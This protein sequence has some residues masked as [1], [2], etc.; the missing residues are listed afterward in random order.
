MHASFSA[1]RLYALL[2]FACAALGAISCGKRD[3][4]A[5][6]PASESPPAS[7]PPSVAT[8]PDTTADTSSTQAS[9]IPARDFA[10]ISHPPKAYLGKSFAYKP[11]VNMTTGVSLRLAKP[12][13]TA[14]RWEQGRILWTPAHPGRYAV[15]IEASLPDG[16]DHKGAKKARQSFILEVS[17]VLN[18]VLRPLPAKAHKGDSIAF[19]LT[20]SRWPAWASASIT[21]RFDWEGDGNWDTESMPLAAQL[22]KRHAY[23]ATGHYTPKIEA[24]YGNFEVR[25]ANGA[26]DIVG[27]VTAALKISP[28]TVEPGSE[29]RVDASAS[30]AEGRL[31]YSLD[32]DGDGKPEWIDSAS[33]QAMLKAPASGLYHPKLTVRDAMGEEDHAEAV[34]RVNARP[35]VE[36]RVR[37]PKDNMAATVDFKIRARDADDSL[38]AVRFTFTGSDQ[39]WE[40]RSAPDSLSEDHAWNLRLRHAYGKVGTYKPKACASSADGREVCQ[41]LKIEIFNAPPESRPGGDLRATLGQPL[42]IDGTG[43]DP[44][45]KIVKWEWDLDGDGKYELVST[46]NGKFQYTFSKEGTFTLVL[47][48]TTADGMTATGKRKV[49]VRKKWKT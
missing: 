32:V 31:R 7:A 30:H 1:P 23:A 6:A 13:D 38:R 37:N 20:Q 15:E 46:E 33:G 40:T 41:E 16:T 27:A 11:S 22:L 4:P 2:W 18:L 35:K 12:A 25:E 21:A 49:E 42:A 45:G 36:F 10:F 44:D 14:M 29:Y 9:E 48:V 8:V 3:E 34:L 43:V 28:D 5:R 17:P 26:I 24:R 19:D 39:D 47:R